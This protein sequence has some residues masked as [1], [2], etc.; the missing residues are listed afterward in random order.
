[1]ELSLQVELK[2][3][4]KLQVEMERQV[5]VQVRTAGSASQM[6]SCRFANDRPDAKC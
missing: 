4:V 1:V 3:E 6:R 2:V 5:Q